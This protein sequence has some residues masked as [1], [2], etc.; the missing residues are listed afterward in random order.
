MTRRAASAEKPRRGRRGRRTATEQALGPAGGPHRPCPG[1]TSQPG[2]DP[3]CLALWGG[4]A[5]QSFS[6]SL[7][8]LRPR[9]GS[10]L[11]EDSQEQDPAPLQAPLPRQEHS[12]RTAPPPPGPPRPTFLPSGPGTRGR[13]LPGDQGTTPDRPPGATPTPAG[14]CRGPG[15]RR[16]PGEAVVRLGLGGQRG[17]GAPHGPRGGGRAETRAWSHAAGSR[18]GGAWRED[19]AHA[20]DRAAGL[21]S[22]TTDTH[23]ENRDKEE[24]EH[25]SQERS[26]QKSGA[27]PQC[28]SGLGDPGAPPRPL[29]RGVG[30]HVSTLVSGG[31]PLSEQEATQSHFLQRKGSRGMG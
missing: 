10:K 4:L 16:S 17:G 7:S 31:P 11:P 15:V 19:S 26:P 3:H 14:C 9:R 30:Q 18:G 24:K 25:D 29:P 23:R 21:V 27:A 6:K 8:S 12:D 28:A 13:V 1:Y 5:P 20:G 22:H 2:R